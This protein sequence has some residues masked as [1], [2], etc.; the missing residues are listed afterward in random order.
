MQG[1][2]SMPSYYPMPNPYSDRLA[3]L[4]NQYQQTVTVPQVQPAPINIRKLQV[5][6]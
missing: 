3:Q 4:Q 1:Y 6:L 2:Q 5:P